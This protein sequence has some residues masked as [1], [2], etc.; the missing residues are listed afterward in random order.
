MQLLIPTIQKNIPRNKSIISKSFIVMPDDDSTSSSKETSDLSELYQKYRTNFSLKNQDEKKL[1]KPYIETEQK[2]ITGPN[3]PTIFQNLLTQSNAPSM[4]ES[5]SYSQVSEQLL[6]RQISTNIDDLDFNNIIND[7]T[8]NNNKCVDR[9]P[10]LVRKKIDR[11]KEKKN[12]VERQPWVGIRN[13]LVR[14]NEV[15]AKKR[16]SQ[17]QRTKSSIRKSVTFKNDNKRR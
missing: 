3:F 15:E 7:L 11:K 5:S 8:L 6:Q 16:G 12:S 10:K 9:T 2:S 17:V 1:I 14:K 13:S 4:D